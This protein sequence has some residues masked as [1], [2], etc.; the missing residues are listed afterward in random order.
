MSP[1]LNEVEDLVT[2][3]TENAEITN[4]L[5]DGTESTSASLQR[6]E[7]WEKRLI[8]QIQ[9]HS[10]GL[11]K[12]GEMCR[13]LIQFNKGNAKSC[14]W[15]G[16]TPCTHIWWLLREKLLLEYSHAIQGVTHTPPE[17]LTARTGVP[18]QQATPV[19]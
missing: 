12:A 2:K 8:H 5:N 19:R 16:T 17:T 7:N 14:I 10:E 11:K 1:L 15:R 3:D 6:I 13:D 4:D 18:L 9:P